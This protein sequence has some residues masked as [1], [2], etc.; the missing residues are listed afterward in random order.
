MLAHQ[1][2]AD[3]VGYKRAG[4]WGDTTVGDYVARW[5]REHPDTDA[6]V[7]DDLRLSWSE[8]DASRA[9]VSPACSPAPGCREARGSRCC[10]LTA[11]VSTSPSSPPSAPA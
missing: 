7:V 2:P 1:D 8:Y 3:V 6:F 9:R 4:W 5:A 10:F 11:S